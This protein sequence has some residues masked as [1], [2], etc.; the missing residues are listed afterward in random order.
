MDPAVQRVISQVEAFMASRDDAKN[1]PR[2]AGQFIH[3]LLLA[4]GAKRCLEIGT[5]YG[6]SG[7]WIGAALRESGGR[8]ITIDR[9][10]R[11]SERAAA[12]FAEAGLTDYIECRTGLATDVLPEIDGPLDFVLSDADKE[13]CVRYAELALPK[14]SDG[15]VVLTDNTL[16]HPAELAEFTAWIRNHDAFWSSN[17]PVGNGMEMS[18]RQPVS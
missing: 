2:E 6:Y 15:A 14:L 8:L 7:L 1:I 9:E 13:N 11:K 5:S 17:V 18:V 12:H 10:A 16:T 3:G 4:T